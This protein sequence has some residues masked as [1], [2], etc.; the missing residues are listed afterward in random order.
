MPGGGTRWVI[1][2]RET[3]PLENCGVEKMHGRRT[4]RGWHRWLAA[5]DDAEELC[6]EQSWARYARVLSSF[7]EEWTWWPGHVGATGGGDRVLG[8]AKALREC[9]AKG[10]VE[11]SE[12]LRGGWV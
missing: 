4:K 1:G 5:C 11:G 10:I 2:C 9:A 7:V 8:G 3:A 12:T 6:V